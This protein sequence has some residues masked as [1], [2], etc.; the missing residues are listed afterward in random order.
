MGD[1]K[2]NGKGGKGKVYK[3]KPGGSTGGDTTGDV[4]WYEKMDGRD[5]D[6]INSY[7]LHEAITAAKE[8]RWHKR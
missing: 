3:G 8:K 1:T 2:G 5:E 6:S 4:K 7:R